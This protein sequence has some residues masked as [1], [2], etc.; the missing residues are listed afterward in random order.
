MI[1]YRSSNKTFGLA[2][3]PLIRNYQGFFIFWPLR[4]YL[5]VTKD[6]LKTREFHN[7]LDGQTVT[8]IMRRLTKEEWIKK[9][10]SVHGDKYDYS[11]FVDPTYRKKVD[12]ICA[13]HGVFKQVLGNHIDGELG[14]PHCGNR[15]K[16]TTQSF[17]EKAK[18]IH[19]DKYDYSQSIYLGNKSKVEIIC[20][21]HGIFKQIATRHLT[22]DGCPSCCESKGE[23]SIRNFLLRKSIMFEPQKKFKECKNK[24]QLPFDFYLPKQNILIEF[25]GQQHFGKSKGM[26]FNYEYIKLTDSIK[27]KFAKEFGFNLIRIPY[28]KINNIE[29][30]LTNII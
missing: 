5:S 2:C 20:A 14:C 11:L 29:S 15:A 23:R 21:K 12:I 27:N 6:E 4:L 3:K 22:G 1:K 19:G 8:I 24:K 16:L 30:I 18:K 9:A 10:T 25:D 13:K 26:K 17:I 28:T 7:S